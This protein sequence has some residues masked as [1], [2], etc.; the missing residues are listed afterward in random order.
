MASEP[1]WQAISARIVSSSPD[2]DN[3]TLRDLK[4]GV[5]GGIDI[6]NV[7]VLAAGSPFL[8]QGFANGPDDLREMK[9]H[10]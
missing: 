8:D 1:R 5:N 6:R 7:T 9:T 2:S 10:G 3:P 4:S